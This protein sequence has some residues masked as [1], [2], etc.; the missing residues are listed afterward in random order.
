MADGYWRLWWRCLTITWTK[1]IKWK[2]TNWFRTL[3]VVMQRL[4]WIL[5]SFHEMISFDLPF[6]LQC[7]KLNVYIGMG[8]ALL[9]RSHAKT[10]FRLN[11]IGRARAKKKKWSRV[12]IMTMMCC[13]LHLNVKYN[14]FQWDRWHDWPVCVF[15]RLTS[16]QYSAPVVDCLHASIPC[17]YWQRVSRDH[18][19]AEGECRG[20]ME[21]CKVIA[22]IAMALANTCCGHCIK[23]LPARRR[24]CGNSSSSICPASARGVHI[25]G[26]MRLY[27]MCVCGL[28][29]TTP[30]TNETITPVWFIMAFASDLKS[31][32]TPKRIICSTVA[33][34]VEVRMK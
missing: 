7:T 25:S 32:N 4:L 28:L 27:Y 16:V 12:C 26:G 23:R 8:N 34:Q 14:R 22:K 18:L 1:K 33:I 5:F 9:G 2:D 3:L 10:L 20:A 19:L 6:Q 15:D 24:W 13:V 30:H 21:V 11:A 29:T 17:P 31:H